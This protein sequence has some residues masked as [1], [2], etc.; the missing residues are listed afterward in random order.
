MDSWIDDDVF[1]KCEL[2]Q[3]KGATIVG[4]PPTSIEN[5]GGEGSPQRSQSPVT[6]TPT[7]R[8]KKQKRTSTGRNTA[9]TKK[10]RK[11]GN[12]KEA[13]S[14]ENP[15]QESRVATRASAAKQSQQPM[16]A[17]AAKQPPQAS[18]ARLPPNQSQKTSL[19]AGIQAVLAAIKASGQHLKGAADGALEVQL[20]DEAMHTKIEDYMLLVNWFVDKMDPENGYKSFLHLFQN[21]QAPSKEELKRLSHQTQKG[22]KELETDDEKTEVEDNGDTNEE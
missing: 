5:E 8:Q 1:T 22:N 16:Q 15:V 13:T 20:I 18:V 6:K 19:P 21:P 10:K 11:K 3:P 9:Q 4:A 7:R 12:L 17:S 14:T 2:G